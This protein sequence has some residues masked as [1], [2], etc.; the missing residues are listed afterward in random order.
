MQPDIKNASEKTIGRQNNILPAG[1]FSNL[2]LPAI[3]IAA[4]CTAVVITHWPALSAKALSFDDDQYLTENMLVQNPSLSSAKQFLTEILEPSTVEGYYQPLTMISLML[5]YALGGRVDNLMPFHATSLVLHAA[6]TALIIILLYLLFGNIWAAAAAG[7]LFGVHPMTVEPIPWVGERKTLLAAFFS[8][9]SLISYV[10]YT[11]R[12]NRGFYII[13]LILYVLALMS[14]PTSVPLPVLM[15]LMD[16]WP[17]KRSSWHSVFEKIPFLAIGGIFAV[18]TYISQSRTALTA[19]PSEYPRGRVP[20][21]VCHNIIFYPYKIVWPVNLSSHYPFPKPLNLSNSMMLTGVIGTGLLIPLLIISLRWTRAIFIGWLFFFVA[22]FPAMGVIGFTDVI[23]SDK[24][25]YL[26]SVGL[27]MVLTSALGVCGKFVFLRFLTAAAVLVLAGA[28]ALAAQRYLVHWRDSVSLFKYMLSLTPDEVSLH[29]NLGAMFQVQGRFAEAVDEYRKILKVEPD[30]L[31]AIYNLGLALQSQGK[32]DEAIVQYRRALELRP[33][34]LKAHGNIG[35]VLQSQ[36]KFDEALK[37]HHGLKLKTDLAETHNNLA[38]ALHAQN[39]L[40]EAV[41]HYHQALSLKPNFADAH[42]NL[43]ITLSEQGKLDEAIGHYRRA[44]ELNP[45]FV[46]A[47]DNLGIALN[48]QGKLVEAINCYNQAL[49]IS[50]GSANL[51]NNLG[52]A[53]QSQG[54]LSEA[55][56]HYQEALRVKPDSAEV[57]NN[58]G[59]ALSALGKLNDAIDHYKQALKIKP[60]YVDACYNLGGVFRLQGKLDEAIDCYR[61]VLK[62]KPDDTEARN[63]LDKALRRQSELYQKAKHQIP[64]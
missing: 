42:Y 16:Y 28:E 3:L 22:I 64:N 33:G 8:L 47:Y 30:Y 35:N 25:A 1:S 52:F 55:I 41:G 56:R 19:L 39:K 49:R 38:L 23:A 44:I 51:H 32:L 62:L 13:C 24:F 57:H 31:K 12:N 53:L 29:N 54:K 7:L 27:L 50:P 2:I 5:D 46:K 43:G 48:Q 36:N 14:K 40:D 21:I 59:N 63:N 58:L 60:D 34:H 9:L 18:I 6:N 37:R 11:Q 45:N 17:L 61:R 10:R 4:V 26:P 15:L 20:L